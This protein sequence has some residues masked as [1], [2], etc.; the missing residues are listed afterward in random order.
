MGPTRL[1]ASIRRSAV[2][3]EV[4]DVEVEWNLSITRARARE[5][6]LVPRALKRRGRRPALR[7]HLG[8]EA[9]TVEDERHSRRAEDRAAIR[10]LEVQVRRGSVASVSGLAEHLARSDMVPKFYGH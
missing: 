4:D 2:V 10:D 5:K 1:R 9:E 7:V 8:L 3:S 6:T